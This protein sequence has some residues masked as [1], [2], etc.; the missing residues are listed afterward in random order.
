VEIA[1]QRQTRPPTRAGGYLVKSPESKDDAGGGSRGAIRAEC[2]PFYPTN[3]SVHLDARTLYQAIN[4]CL[5]AGPRDALG[6][7]L[8]PRTRSTESWLTP[9]QHSHLKGGNQRN[10]SPMVVD[11]RG[12]RS[13]A[14]D[15]R[16]PSAGRVLS[17][18]GCVR[19]RRAMEHVGVLA[20]SKRCL[21]QYPVSVFT[22]VQAFAY[23]R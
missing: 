11:P 4:H 17:R 16:R 23:W 3:V 18:A 10:G 2:E 9:G 1:G 13:R 5:A 21:Y 7:L 22:P 8:E 6:G 12:I 14:R 19:Q 15:R 20:R